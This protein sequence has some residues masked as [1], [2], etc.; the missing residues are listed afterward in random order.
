MFWNVVYVK[1]HTAFWRFRRWHEF[2]D[3]LRY[4]GYRMAFT[5]RILIVGHNSI[6]MLPAMVFNRII[7]SHATTRGRFGVEP[8]IT[9]ASVCRAVATNIWQFGSHLLLSALF[10]T[11]TMHILALEHSVALVLFVSN[12]NYI[13]HFRVYLEFCWLKI[14]WFALV[15]LRL[16]PQPFKN[17]IRGPKQEG[18]VIFYTHW[19]GNRNRIE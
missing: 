16:I 9:P 6:V 8:K 7:D 12:F 11:C 18:R 1:L 2:V 15:I 4:Y 10:S 5:L 13:L 17:N 14:L 3:E 19:N